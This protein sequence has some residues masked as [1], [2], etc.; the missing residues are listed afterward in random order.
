MYRSIEIKFGLFGVVWA[1]PNYL[2]KNRSLFVHF[3]TVRPL[4][5]HFLTVKT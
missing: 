2:F 3:F 1:N 5:D 4:S